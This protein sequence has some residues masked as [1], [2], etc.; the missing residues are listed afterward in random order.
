MTSQGR[1]SCFWSPD[2]FLMGYDGQRENKKR[3]EVSPLQSLVDRSSKRPPG[4]TLVLPAFPGLTCPASS[5][6][7]QWWLGLGKGASYG[8]CG[9]VCTGLGQQA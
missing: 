4:K 2:S 9:G 1:A 7:L 6:F 3:L 8:R 5:L